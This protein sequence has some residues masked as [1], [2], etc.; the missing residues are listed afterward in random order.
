[1]T[2][3]DIMFAQPGNPESLRDHE[4][5]T[6]TVLL[7]VLAAIL[8][9]LV[10]AFF[11]AAFGGVFSPPAPVEDKPAELTLVDLAP[12]SKNSAFIENDESKKAPEPKEKT[13]ESNANSIGA[14]ELA[15][16]GELPLPS[17]TGKD[18]PFMDL[19]THQHS[20][21]TKGAQPQPSAAPQENPNPSAAPQTQ[22]APV[23]AAEQFA[24]LTQQPTP[25]VEKSVTSP[26]TRSAYRSMK[27]RTR[28]AGRI[29]NRGVSSVN[30][31]GTPLG[32]YQK[33]L[34]DAIGSRWYAFIDRQIDLVTIGTARVVFVVDRSGHVKNLKVV[35]NSSN[36]TLANVCIQSIQEAQLPPMPDDLATT[37]PPEGLDMD[38]PFTIFPNR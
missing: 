26:Q 25:P 27:Q 2:T 4:Y 28:I 24:M 33:F 11:L 38:I 31:L 16:T 19:E 32:R 5:E 13:F 17:Q 21:E 12:T 22:P 15:A 9:H 34:L 6:R 20:L 37:L 8:I 14:S 7:A 29:T 10:V 30:A 23:T 3:A 36:E 18:R 35:E 1:M